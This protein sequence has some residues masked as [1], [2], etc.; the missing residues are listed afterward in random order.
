MTHLEC[1]NDKRET[2]DEKCNRFDRV[3]SCEFHFWIATQVCCDETRKHCESVLWESMQQSSNVWRGRRKLD[4][5]NTNFMHCRSLF[6]RDYLVLSSSGHCFYALSS[7]W[8]NKKHLSV[9]LERFARPK[10]HLFD[11]F[12]E[13]NTKELKVSF[14][15]ETTIRTRPPPADP[16]KFLKKTSKGREVE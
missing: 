5:I 13:S 14:K 15:M 10:S 1:R 7:G 12:F 11:F 3:E 2:T 8:I 4:R 16:K 6:F 9:F